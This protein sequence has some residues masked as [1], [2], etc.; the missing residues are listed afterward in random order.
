LRSLHIDTDQRVV[1]ST[2]SFPHRYS[3]A[4]APQ[5]IEVAQEG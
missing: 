2:F 5:W 3:V 1:V 4:S